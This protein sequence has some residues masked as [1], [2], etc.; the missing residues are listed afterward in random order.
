M[1]TGD[2]SRPTTVPQSL[3]DKVKPREEMTWGD[4]RGRQAAPLLGHGP[5]RPP[6]HLRP[7]T[8]TLLALLQ[9]TAPRLQCPCDLVS[10]RGAGETPRGQWQAPQ[11]LRV[12][13]CCRGAE[14]QDATGPQPA[15]CPPGGGVLCAPSDALVRLS[16]G[17]KARAEASGVT[18][19][20]GQCRTHTQSWC[21]SRGCV[22]TLELR[23]LE[24]RLR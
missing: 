8:W 4:K 24:C 7:A 20:Q 19:M 13:G 11:Q 2:T 17:M 14:A 5:T 1:R 16:L 21:Q 10:E 15:H 9:T 12:P 18:D 6:L 22:L 23:V 3:E